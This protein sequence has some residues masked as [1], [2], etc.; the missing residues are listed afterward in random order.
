[1]TIYPESFLRRILAI[2]AILAT[3][4]V[5]PWISYDPINLPKMLIVVTGAALL[6]GTFFMI[7]INLIGELPRV[8]LYLSIFFALALIYSIFVNESPWSQQ[9]WG[10]WGRSTGLLTYLSLV[11]LMLSAS[12]MK[13]EKSVESIRSYFEKLSYFISL[14]TLFQAGGIDPI[15]WSQKAM[16]ATLGNINFMSSFLGLATVSIISRL[17]N[18]K[19]PMSSYLYF[20]LVSTLN[21]WLIWLSGSIQG[22]GI[23]LCGVSVIAALRVR[24]RYGFRFAIGLS[25]AI[26]PLGLLVFLGTAGVGPLRA[27]FQ[28]TVGFRVDYWKAGYRMLLANWQHG[29][30]VDSYGDYYQQYRDI[31]AVTST[32]PQRVTNT[33]HNIFLD[34]ATGSGIMSGIILLSIF[35]ITAHLILKN[36]KSGNY[37]ETDIALASIWVGFLFFCLISI[38][39]IGVGVWGFVFMGLIHNKSFSKI[40]NRN[41]PKQLSHK[42]KSETN[43]LENHTYVAKHKFLAVVFAG[44]LGFSVSALPNYLDI[45]MLQAVKSRDFSKMMK[46]AQSPFSTVFYKDKLQ[47]LLIDSGMDDE[48]LSFAWKE[49]KK[50]ERNYVALK[51]IAFS[52]KASSQQRTLAISKLRMIDPLNSDLMQQLDTFESYRD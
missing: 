37:D 26:I 42:R 2:T 18:G 6:L 5:S 40:D 29:I 51:V 4:A 46:V 25:I 32:G 52:E 36:F 23:I 9:L 13:T 44:L 11:V 30:G 31:S 41:S 33:A 8:Y 45:E 49:I 19:L 17:V 43:L 35:A 39:Q 48:A 3:V 10:A 20:C 24:V 47:S 1:M 12:M 16:I 27:M 50:N 38:N 7:G 15:N 22:L 14:Y 28:E 21:I 34:V